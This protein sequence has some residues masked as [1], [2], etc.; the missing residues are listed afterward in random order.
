MG[1]VGIKNEGDIT[2]RVRA[3]VSIQQLMLHLHYTALEW[4]LGM[5]LVWVEGGTEW[6]QCNVQQTLDLE[7]SRMKGVPTALP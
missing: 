5:C 6:G 1:W 4:R 2:L 3:P 7:S